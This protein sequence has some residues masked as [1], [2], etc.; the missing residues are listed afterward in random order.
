MELALDALIAGALTFAAAFAT[1]YF[2][3]NFLKRASMMVFVLY[4][5]A[6]GAALLYFF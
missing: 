3:M 4:R 5:V 1:M 6:M 2:L